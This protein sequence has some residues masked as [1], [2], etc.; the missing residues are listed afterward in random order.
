VRAS[1]VD[2]GPNF[3]V[4]SVLR[5]G[6]DGPVMWGWVTEGRSLEWTHEADWSGMIS[7]PRVLWLTPDGH[8]ASAPVKAL[9]TLRAGPIAR[10]VPARFEADLVLRGTAPARRGSRLAPQPTSG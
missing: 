1:R 7:L 2:A 10:S 5:D 6:G 8:L 3:H 4:A 9:A